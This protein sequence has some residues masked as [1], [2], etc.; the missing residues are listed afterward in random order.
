MWKK[1]IWPWIKANPQKTMGVTQIVSG[2]VLASLPSLSHSP[3]TQP[4]AAAS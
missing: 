2:S 1:T 3:S 4:F